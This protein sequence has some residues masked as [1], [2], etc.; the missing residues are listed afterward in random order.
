MEPLSHYIA[1]EA[2]RAD[3]IITSLTSG[4]LADTSRH[5]NSGELVIRAGRPVLIVADNA[6]APGFDRILV[7]W[8]D[9]REARRAVTDALPLLKHAAQVVVVEVAAED[10]L[11]EARSRVD[12]VVAWLKRHGVAAD[13]VVSPT[14]G[15][16]ASQLA[17]IAGDHDTEV[18]VAGAYGH[19]RLREWAFGGV[20]SDLLLR[21]NSCAL[22]SH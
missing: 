3:L 21:A 1:D 19:N 15:D 22:L 6:V 4:L 8:K 11:G 16:D 10:E 20:T 12:G 14:T 13:A 7:A 17:A 2:R 9:R 18:I 5:A